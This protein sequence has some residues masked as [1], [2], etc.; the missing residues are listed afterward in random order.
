MPFPARIAGLL[1]LEFHDIAGDGVHVV[2]VLHTV[3]SK[4][5]LVEVYAVVAVKVRLEPAD[6][7][8]GN[9][10]V[11]ECGCLGGCFTYIISADVR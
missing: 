4:L 8:F 2:V 11:C 5:E 9:A 10:R 1:L 7:R 6:I 3:R